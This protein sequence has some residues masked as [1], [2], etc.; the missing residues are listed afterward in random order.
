MNVDTIELCL[1]GHLR[2]YVAEPPARSGVAIQLPIVGQETVGQILDDL[3]IEP[4]EV[5][6]LFIN[7][8]LLPRSI[9]P[10]TLGYPLAALAPLSPEGYLDSPIRPGDR[11]G[12]FPRNMSSVVV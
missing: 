10:I 1:F 4:T 5:G 8:R 9:Y 6:N 7:G 11:L 3:G 2:R 12:I